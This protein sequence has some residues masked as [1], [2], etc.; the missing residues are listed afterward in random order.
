MEQNSATL[1]ALISD[2][3]E[4]YRVIHRTPEVAL[5]TDGEHH[6]GATLAG[7]PLY[8]ASKAAHAH[9]LGLG[10]MHTDNETGAVILSLTPLRGIAPTLVG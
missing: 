7:V 10:E 4:S 1:Q 3:P 2:L 8:A 6:G 9:G 5:W